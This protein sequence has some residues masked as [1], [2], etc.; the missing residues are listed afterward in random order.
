MGYSTT[1]RCKYN[2]QEVSSAKA[3][4]VCLMY[5]TT[6]HE[7]DLRGTENKQQWQGS[8]VC[9]CT[10]LLTEHS[11][12]QRSSKPP[13]LSKFG[14]VP[15]FSTPEGRLLMQALWEKVADTSNEMSSL[16]VVW[17]TPWHK[18]I[19]KWIYWTNK[20]GYFLQ[21]G[22]KLSVCVHWTKSFVLLSCL[23]CAVMQWPKA[24]TPIELSKSKGTLGKTLHLTERTPPFPPHFKLFHN[25]SW[26]IHQI[27]TPQGR[28][29]SKASNEKSSEA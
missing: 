10:W 9:P 24:W 22:W 29:C 23:R 6:Q 12:C 15:G 2:S 27:I 8:T 19:L 4:F 17:G 25:Y 16:K 20:W 28:L 7:C 18:R 26:H 11:E 14:C 3:I 5:W 21:C 1:A 13:S